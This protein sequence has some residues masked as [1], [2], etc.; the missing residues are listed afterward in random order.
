MQPLTGQHHNVAI[1]DLKLRESK[2]T[3]NLF[4]SGLVHHI[5]VAD[6][7]DHQFPRFDFQITD[8]QHGRKDT[9]TLASKYLWNER[10]R[11]QMVYITNEDAIPHPL[12]ERMYVY[13]KLSVQHIAHAKIV[14]TF[15]IIPIVRGTTSICLQIQSGKEGEKE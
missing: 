6:H 15:V 5:I 2:P 12:S 10:Q 7:L 8:P 4:L 14:I 3:R 11:T 13:L 1:R 9:T